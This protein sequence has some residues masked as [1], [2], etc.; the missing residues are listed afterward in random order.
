M[1]SFSY[2]ASKKWLIHEII[3]WAPSAAWFGCADSTKSK[4]AMISVANCFV[5]LERKYDVLLPDQL[6]V[7]K[8]S[9]NAIYFH[10]LRRILTSDRAN[11][12]RRVT[13]PSWMVHLYLIT[14]AKRRTDRWFFSVIGRI[15]VNHSTFVVINMVGR[16]RRWVFSVWSDIVPVNS[17]TH[18]TI[19]SC[20]N[21]LYGTMRAL[22][23]P[24]P[25]WYIGKSI[26]DFHCPTVI[27]HS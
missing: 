21:C 10:I 5:F 4:Y 18:K 3:C 11:R 16:R 15:D 12:V 25:R 26:Q 1:S 20:C 2:T 7:A 22:R 24:I 14:N 9:G 27:K 23:Y 6:W 19:W 8:L 17:L 13:L